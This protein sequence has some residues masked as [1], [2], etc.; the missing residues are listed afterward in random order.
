M[1]MCMRTFRRTTITGFTLGVGLSVIAADN[2]QGGF[3]SLLRNSPFGA[4]LSTVAALSGYDP[5]LEF[6]GVLVEERRIL[7]SIFEN[8]SGL[9]RWVE[10]NEAGH[11]FTVRSYDAAKGEVKVVC[12]ARE[13]SLGLKSKMVLG[14]SYSSVVAPVTAP[15][16]EPDAVA[17][18]AVIARAAARRLAL[19]Q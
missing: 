8:S 14:G 6:R 16:S 13:F 18:L 5:P 1:G 7:F 10:L 3:E 15:T 4:S 19:G 17:H 11:S 9:S 2:P 12:Q